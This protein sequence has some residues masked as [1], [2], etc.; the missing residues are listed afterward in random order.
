LIFEK[1]DLLAPLR[2]GMLAPP[3][4]MYPG[5]EDVNYYRGEVKGSHPSQD[6]NK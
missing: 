3:H 4:P 6:V 2:Q 1:S 5:M